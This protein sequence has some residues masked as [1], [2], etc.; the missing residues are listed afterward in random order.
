MWPPLKEFVQGVRESPSSLQGYHSMILFNNLFIWGGQLQEIIASSS[1]FSWEWGD[2]DIDQLQWGGRKTL[3][4]K[5]ANFIIPVSRK[6]Y[7]W[8]QSSNKILS[9]QTSEM[10]FLAMHGHLNLAFRNVPSYS[11][12]SSPGQP[13]HTVQNLLALQS[14]LKHTHHI[15]PCSLVHTVSKILPACPVVL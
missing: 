13:R 9:G 14:A 5:C 3:V 6:P 4:S 12:V 10:V 8:H 11:P 1:S 2:F 15:P 7:P